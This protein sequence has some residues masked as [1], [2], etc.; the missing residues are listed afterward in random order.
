[1]VIEML[2]SAFQAQAIEEACTMDH[3]NTDCAIATFAMISLEFKDRDSC[4]DVAQWNSPR[5]YR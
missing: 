1:M 4:W 3:S 2:F 5:Q